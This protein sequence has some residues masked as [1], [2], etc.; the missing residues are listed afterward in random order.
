MQRTHWR[1]PLLSLVLLVIGLASTRAPVRAAEPSLD[2]PGT[3]LIEVSS[4]RTIRVGR[5]AMVAWSP[6]SQAIALTE[7]AVG[8]PQPRLRFVQVAD[9][10]AR[11][12][13]VPD[14]GQIN[15]LRWA[16][17]GSAL[18]FTLTRIGRDPG[19]A[20]MVVD[21]ASGAVRQLVRGN[22]GDL[23]WTPDSSGISIITLEEGGGAIVTLDARSGE[24]R[25]T[26]PD[27]KDASCKR[28][29]TWSPD[30]SLLAWG[31][32]GLR[33]GC[34]DAGNWGIWVW[35]PAKKSTTQ[36]YQG[37]ADVPHWLANGEL[38]AMISAPETN[39]P[40]I[41]PLSIVRLPRDGG[42]PQPIARDVPRMLPEPPQLVQVSGNVVLYPISTCEQG[43]AHVW[44]P[45]QT[46]ETRVTP[47]IVYA[48]RPWLA[49]D[50][51]ALAYV[52]IGEPNQLLVAPLDQGQPRVLAS[53]T[54][55]LQVGTAGPWDAGGDWSPDGQRLAVEVTTE[56]FKDC[57]E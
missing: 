52:Q 24:I 5:N 18:A 11:D 44:K 39:P 15:H 27:A 49:P 53:S 7:P 33:E 23:A 4:G 38:V 3:Y 45:D 12:V 54:A 8:P 28:G 57:P 21:P 43:E 1:V 42:D 17:D 34:G 16:P 29:L 46:A 31:G 47:E 30:G 25:E 22:V 41:P 26:V 40:A 36:L 50:G 55:G 10:A 19:P 51:N 6:D 9:G 35:Q 20:L 37:P 13:K 14:Q 48:Y 32:P 56:Q 2:D